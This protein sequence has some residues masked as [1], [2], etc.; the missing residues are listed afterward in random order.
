MTPILPDE[1]P[2]PEAR[3]RI[4]ERRQTEDGFGRNYYLVEITYLGGQEPTSTWVQS[5]DNIER[6]GTEVERVFVNRILQYVSPRE[7]E[8]FEN[9]QF[10]IEAEAQAVAEKEEEVEQIRRRL[11]KN[12]RMA[13]SKKGKGKQ[14]PNG[15]DKDPGLQSTGRVRGKQRSKGEYGLVI[16]SDAHRKLLQDEIVRGEPGQTDDQR[17]PTL[18]DEIAETSIDLEDIESEKDVPKPVSPGLMR[19]SFVANSALPLS[20]VQQHRLA[21]PAALRRGHPEVPDIGCSETPSEVD[22]D[23]SMSS[24]AMQL[25]FEGK[26]NKTRIAMSDMVSLHNEDAHRSKRQKMENVEPQRK[27]LSSSSQIVDM[28]TRRKD[29]SATTN[30]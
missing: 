26:F 25:H 30:P 3:T 1:C 4:L 13:G 19:S 29:D 10:R 7:L 20:P 9:E 24:A 15:L 28:D 16:G 6:Q 12:A 27:L 21:L 14:T 8:R 22:E 5:S 18:E 11:K 23:G 17:P 2:I